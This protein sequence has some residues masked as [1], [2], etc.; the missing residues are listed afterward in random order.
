MA[1]ALLQLANISKFYKSSQSVVIGVDSVDLSLSRGEFVV[2]TGES[3]SGKT[4]LASVIGGILPYESGEMFY[5]GKP[6]S[7]Y[8]GLDWD[9]YRR[10]NIAFISQNYGIIPGATVLKNVESALCIAGMDIRGAREAAKDILRRVDLF[11]FKNRRAARLSSGQKQRLSIA[12]ALAKPAPILIADEPTG[13]LDSENS[14]KVIKLLA[15]AAADRLVILV[16]H[17]FEG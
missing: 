10:D 17:E 4:T 15:D 1:E 13:N 3:G 7:H 11:E 16:T 9:R 2:V 14:R 12:R 5:D 6:T 8:G